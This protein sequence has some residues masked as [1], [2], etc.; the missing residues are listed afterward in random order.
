LEKEGAAVTFW[1]FAFFSSIH[2]LFSWL[3]I[4]ETKNKTLEEMEQVFFKK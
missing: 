1:A 2:L 4:R 3:I